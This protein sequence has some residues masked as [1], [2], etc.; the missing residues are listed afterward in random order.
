MA[1]IFNKTMPS[2]ILLSIS[3]D[4]K[5][6][7]QNWLRIKEKYP[8]TFR[9]TQFY[10][11]DK[12]IELRQD[13]LDKIKMTISDDQIKAFNHQAELIQTAW[14]KQADEIIKKIPPI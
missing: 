14:P 11:F 1:V 7:L 3:Y 12:N 8:E 6:D 13:N 5:Q 9:F 2:P 10:P 4:P